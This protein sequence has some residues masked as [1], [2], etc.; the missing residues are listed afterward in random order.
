[1]FESVVNRIVDALRSLFNED[2]KAMN[3]HLMID[4]ESVE[5]YLMH[6]R[7]NSTKYR[8]DRPLSD[9]IETLSKE[10][11]TIDNV[12]KQKLNNYN[13]TKG[14]LQQLERKKQ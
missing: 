13:L 8:A 3:E 7:W 6:W 5:E 10:M 4:D 2:A 1:M 14:Q 12:M 9:L 11:Q